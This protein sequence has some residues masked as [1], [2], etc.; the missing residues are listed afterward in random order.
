M[1]AL[2]HVH[3]GTGVDVTYPLHHYYLGAK[4][5]ELTLGAAPTHLARL[6]RFLAEGRAGF[7]TNDA[8][9]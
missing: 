8:A 1:S 9:A 3:G 5:L 4:H 6:G 2:A 7:G